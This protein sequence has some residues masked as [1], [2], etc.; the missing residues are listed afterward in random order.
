MNAAVLLLLLPAFLI[1]W[2]GEL[3]WKS[4]K[5]RLGRHPCTRWEKCTCFCHM[6]P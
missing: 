2:A 1:R 6:G 5:C 4:L 3:P